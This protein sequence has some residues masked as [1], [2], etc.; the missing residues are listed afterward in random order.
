MPRTKIA[1]LGAALFFL[2]MIGSALLAAI[3]VWNHRWVPALVT[4][5]LMIVFGFLASIFAVSSLNLLKFL[6]LVAWI[7]AAVVGIIGWQNG[8][9]SVFVGG[10]ITFLLL[11]FVGGLAILWQ[12]TLERIILQA[13]MKRSLGEP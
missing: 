3:G 13:W 9:T 4:L 5:V 6:I 10:L 1:W 7:V 8:E 11:P 2:L 12:Q